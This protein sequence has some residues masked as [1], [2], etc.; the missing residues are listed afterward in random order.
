MKNICISTFNG[1]KMKKKFIMFFSIILSV[2]LLSGCTFVNSIVPKAEIP[3][4]TSSEQQ[5]RIAQISSEYVDT[6][7]TVMVVR[8]SDEVT[9]SFGSGV[10]VHED[11][12][13]ATN[14]H[15][16]D[17]VLQDFNSLYSLKVVFN[18]SDFLHNATIEWANVMLDVAIIKVEVN[19]PV[20]APM[21]DRFIFAPE[22]ERLYTLETVIAIGTPISYSYKNTVTLGTIS[23]K[24]GRISSSDGNVYEQLIQHTA[25]INHGNS[26]GGLFDLHGNLIGLNT[27]GYDDAHGLFFAV[28]I[29]P[30][31]DVLDKVV[32]AHNA[33][34]KFA[35]GVLGVEAVDRY[36]AKDFGSNFD[37]KGLSVVS[38]LEGNA[39]SGLLQVGDEIVKAKVGDFTIDID[40]RNEFVYALLKT[41]K[42]TNLQLTIKRD[43]Q[44][45]TV[46][47]VLG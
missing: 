32:A 43:N 41:T 34:H 45:Q 7:V 31:I 20:Y 46:D 1:E 39:A 44:T 21:K 26:G 40:I 9:E 28:S 18:S 5:E 24:E 30:I 4:L 47:L 13:I 14:Y 36:Q 3:V 22:E 11:G 19:V 37:G 38:V 35:L 17:K 8:A 27:L 12:F 15:V 23:S 33:G 10:V 29:Y 6:V 2:V 16:I 42:G 25:F